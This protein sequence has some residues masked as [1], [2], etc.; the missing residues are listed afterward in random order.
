MNLLDPKILLDSVTIA[1]SKRLVVQ[2]ISL[3]LQQHDLLC[4]VGR[5]GCGKTTLLRAV[6]GLISLYRGRILLD[7]K[8][9]TRPTS[10]MAMIFQHFGLFPWKTVQANIEYGL[11][12][13]GM[14]DDSTVS[15]LVELMGLSDYAQ[16]YPYQLSGG[17]QQR[18]GIARALAVQPEVLLLDEPFSAVDAITRE[19]LQ[20][21][22]LRLWEDPQ[23]S[24]MT[25]ILVTHDLDEAILLGDRIVVLGG[26]PGGICLELK[27]PIPRPRNP[28]DFRFHPAYRQLR[29]QLWKALNDGYLV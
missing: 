3:A 17:M 9:I 18:V 21:E 29:S 24:N 19:M 5:S 14:R 1:F 25:A 23:H 4:I 7:N 15:R 13:Q 12:V 8:A 10:R 6:A 2:D 27:V 11:S 22:L 28:Q 20:G 16:C 26:T